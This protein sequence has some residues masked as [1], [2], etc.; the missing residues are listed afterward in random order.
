MKESFINAHVNARALFVSDGVLHGHAHT[1]YRYMPRVVPCLWRPT[2]NEEVVLVAPCRRVDG[3]MCMCDV[4][5]STYVVLWPLLAARAQFHAP[6]RNHYCT[7]LVCLV[8]AAP[9]LSARSCT[10]TS[11]FTNNR[12]TVVNTP[13]LQRRKLLNERII[14]P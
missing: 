5:M 6:R 2:S 12:G 4:C 13:P 14:E 10:S 11:T 8:T 1:P 3:C 9:L 7:P